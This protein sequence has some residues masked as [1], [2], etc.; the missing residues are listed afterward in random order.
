MPE[1]S[2]GGWHGDFSFPTYLW[3]TWGYIIMLLLFKFLML[4]TSAWYISLGAHPKKSAW[5]TL[6]DWIKHL[7]GQVQEEAEQRL[8]SPMTVWST[9]LSIGWDSNVQI[10][11]HL[12]VVSPKHPICHLPAS[13]GWTTPGFLLLT[14]LIICCVLL[15]FPWLP[16]ASVPTDFWD[17][18]DYYPKNQVIRF[19]H[20]LEGES[21]L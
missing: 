8:C 20:V 17:L 21:G 2:T 4:N 9:C 5:A 10:C 13:F 19:Y 6:R 18:M 7:M 14:W 3:V 1:L 12:P 15:G 16:E 11:L